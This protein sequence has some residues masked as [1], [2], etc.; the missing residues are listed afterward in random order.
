VSKAGLV[1]LG[2][3]FGALLAFLV[4]ELIVLRREQR[5]NRERE[6]DQNG[7]PGPSV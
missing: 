4:R 7:G 6:L 3:G 5:R 2:L 1:E